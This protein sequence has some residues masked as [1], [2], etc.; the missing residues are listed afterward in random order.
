MLVSV[1]IL[2]FQGVGCR[3]G[4]FGFLVLCWIY[5]GFMLVLFG[6]YVGFML[7]VCWLYV[8]FMLA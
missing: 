8:G 2:R 5:V 3:P 4:V 6:F 1:V 7:V